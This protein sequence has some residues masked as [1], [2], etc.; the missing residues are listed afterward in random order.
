MGFDDI[1]RIQVCRILAWA[2]TSYKVF[3]RMF[4]DLPPVIVSKAFG[5]PED[6]GLPRMVHHGRLGWYPISRNR[7]RV[8]QKT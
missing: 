4:P 8:V 6:E 3:P 5:K 7:Q 1:R 2:R